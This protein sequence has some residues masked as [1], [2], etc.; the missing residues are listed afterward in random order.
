MQSL[1]VAA[2]ASGGGAMRCYTPGSSA[3]SVG[4]F[5]L[6]RLSI[7]SRLAL[8]TEGDE[9]FLFGGFNAF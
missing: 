6:C 8:R 7:F 3:A 2:G 5:L 9:M 1:P 4:P